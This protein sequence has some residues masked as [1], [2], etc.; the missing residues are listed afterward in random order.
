MNSTIEQILSLLAKIYADK[1]MANTNSH[2]NELA[3][4][5]IEKI[6]ENLGIVITKSKENYESEID[7]KYDFIMS[8]VQKPNIYDLIKNS[9]EF[10]SNQKEYTHKLYFQFSD[11]FSHIFE[12]FQ[13]FDEL[14]GKITTKDFT[15]DSLKS[16]REKGFYLLMIQRDEIT[17]ALETLMPEGPL[18]R[19]S[20]PQ[21]LLLL[22]KLGYLDEWYNSFSVK[23]NFYSFLSLLLNQ[24][25][26]NIKKYITIGSGLN[27]R[28]IKLNKKTKFKYKT[29]ENKKSVDKIWKELGL[30]QLVK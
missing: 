9:P 25:R 12:D 10:V 15:Y 7:Y 21:Q 6:T 11:L 28:F 20:I 4:R 26:N 8:Q 3:L 19:F 27:Q 24:D 18:K 2:D 5:L 13:D 22:E 17:T 30:N 29:I 16:F 14:L 1:L 23:E